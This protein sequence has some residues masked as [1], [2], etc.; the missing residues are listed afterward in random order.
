MRW[1]EIE[2][3]QAVFE[4]AHDPSRPFRVIAGSAE[5]IAVG[6]KFDVYLAGNSTLVTVVEGRV[7]VGPMLATLGGSGASH[8]AL[9]TMQVSTGQRVRVIDG[10]LPSSPSQVDTARATAWLRHQISF[11]AAPLEDVVAEFNRYTAT[12]IE[13]ETPALRV[14]EISG[15]FAVDDTESFVAFLRS[16]NGVGVDVTAAQIRVFKH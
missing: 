11:E 3:G 1:V 9:G 8:D 2:R 13:I 12:P 7:T 15:V 14:L 5:V 6:T 10:Q 16:L 4:I